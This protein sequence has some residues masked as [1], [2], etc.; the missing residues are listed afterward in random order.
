NEKIEA[1][2]HFSRAHLEEGSAVYL[3][4]RNTYGDTFIRVEKEGR[5]MRYAVS[6]VHETVRDEIGFRMYASRLL[7]E[8]IRMRAEN[9]V[10]SEEGIYLEFL[11]LKEVDPIRLRLWMRR[12][13]EVGES[14]V[15]QEMLEDMTREAF[16][17]RSQRDRSPVLYKQIRTEMEA[18]WNSFRFDIQQIEVAFLDS[19]GKH[20]VE[21][22]TFEDAGT[23]DMIEEL[24]QAV[25]N[26]HLNDRDKTQAILLLGQSLKDLGHDREALSILRQGL[27]LPPVAKNSKILR[28]LYRQVFQ[29]QSQNLFKQQR[30]RSV[31]D[32]EMIDFLNSSFQ[33]SLSRENLDQILELNHPQFRFVPITIESHV[34][35]LRV[36]LSVESKDP[37]HENVAEFTLDLN[38]PHDESTF[39]GYLLRSRVKS[40][41]Q[42]Q[43]IATHAFAVVTK[44]LRALS[45]ED[46]RFE[47]EDIGRYT[48]LRLGAEFAKPEEQIRFRAY[49]RSFISDR[50]EFKKWQH[51]T[52]SHFTADTI[53]Q[54]MTSMPVSARNDFLNFFQGHV[55]YRFDLRKNSPNFKIFQRYFSRRTL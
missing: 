55:L 50:P 39:A 43:R 26:P 24:R 21:R 3:E 10:R 49:L 18:F 32:Q 13:M 46:L 42:N 5:V 52:D 9:P 20:Q 4:A 33:V 51:L 54:I 6:A 30:E 34:G 36:H 1:A 15:I 35:G 22:V 47:A 29:S 48:W 11:R 8:L 12:L 40:E 44:F 37:P 16:L 45:F 25:R 19:R 53:R 23:T 38:I 7:R 27:A 14:E 2:L 41:Y 17:R 31:L 28:D